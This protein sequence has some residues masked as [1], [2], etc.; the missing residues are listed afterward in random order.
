MDKRRIPKDK[1]RI[2]PKRELKNEPLRCSACNVVFPDGAAWLEHFKSCL[3][4]QVRADMLQDYLERVS[5]MMRR[6]V[7]PL[8]NSSSQ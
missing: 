1:S 8:I 5:L 4:R 6:P 7:L 3:P 2:I